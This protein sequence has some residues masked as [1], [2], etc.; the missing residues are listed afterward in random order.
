MALISESA[1]SASIRQQWRLLWPNENWRQADSGRLA[2][3]C[4]DDRR[5]APDRLLRRGMD[6][7]LPI[8]LIAPSASLPD[9]TKT[10]NVVTETDV[11]I[12]WVLIVAIT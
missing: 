10:V 3:D 11:G 7:T 5:V 12:S 2:N 4:L 9:A 1:E 8:A 6:L